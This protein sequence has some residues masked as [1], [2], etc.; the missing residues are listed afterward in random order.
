MRDVRM[1]S[2]LTAP[3]KLRAASDFT[4]ARVYA[5]LN[6]NAFQL[7]VWNKAGGCWVADSDPTNTCITYTSSAP[8]GT[9]TNLSQGDSFGFGALTAG[10]TPGQTT[11]GQSAQGLDN[12]G[13][14]IANTACIEFN[15]RSIPI[16]TT[17][18]PPLPT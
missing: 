11:I 9:V 8:S 6:G 10:P 16:A 3:D 18:P 17:T 12:Y 7:Q 2:V 15:Y 14:A 13:T 4:H 5:N 1:I